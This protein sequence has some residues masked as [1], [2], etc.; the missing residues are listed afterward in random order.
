MSPEDP[1]KAT[2]QSGESAV[3]RWLEARGYEVEA[4]NWRCRTGE[5]D[6]VAVRGDLIA[7]V[8]VRSVTTDFV[9][10]PTVTVLPAKQARVARAADAYLQARA[11]WPERIRFDVA[12]VRIDGDVATVDYLENAFVPHVAF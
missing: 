6:I 3:C 2:G 8:E 1:R 12:G 9:G 7:F 5:L 10:S 4:R 11:R